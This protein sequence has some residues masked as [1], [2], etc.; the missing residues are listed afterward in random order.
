MTMG[1]EA[2]IHRLARTDGYSNAPM[3]LSQTGV[4]RDTASRPLEASAGL[5]PYD[6][7]SPL[8]SDGARKQRWIS[9]PD[10]RTVG[11][12][13]TGSWTF[14]QNTV[15]VNHFDHILDEL[16]SDSLWLL[17]TRVL[18]RGANDTYYG[19]TYMWNEAGTYATLVLE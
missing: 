6:V 8:W 15:L 13:P 14:P 18:V 19:L 9:V 7:I 10:G 12:A 1:A 4:F 5:I 17:V 3:Q 11:F 16:D 2:K